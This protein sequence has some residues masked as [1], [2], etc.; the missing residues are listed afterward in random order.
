MATDLVLILDNI[1]S[2][3][4]VGAIFRTADAFRV[5]EIVCAGYTPTPETEG[6][7]K[8]ALGAEITVPWRAESLE[9]SIK[10]LR[11]DGYQIVALEIGGEDIAKFK[12]PEKIA[13]ILGNEVEG[14]NPEILK[15]VDHRLEIPMRGKKE[16]LNVSVACGI[17][18]FALQSGRL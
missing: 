6:L 13:L 8:T 15:S 5:Q 3:Y 12:T 11:A 14:V 2:N 10:R 9:A 7:K 17:A 1:R 4:N 16:S 18:L